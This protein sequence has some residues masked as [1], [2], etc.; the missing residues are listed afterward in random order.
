VKIQLRAAALEPI[1]IRPN[2]K[3]ELK[4][5]NI[6]TSE[7]DLNSATGQLHETVT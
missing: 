3:V 6:T 2:D 5:L 7:D 4:Q 1:S